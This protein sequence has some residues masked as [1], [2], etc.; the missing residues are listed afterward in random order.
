MNPHLIVCDL[1]GSLLNKEGNITSLSK[2]VLNTLID[3]GHTVVLA[4]G[5]P[6]GGAIDKYNELQLKTPLITDNGGSVDN[7][8]DPKFARQKTYIPLFVMHDLFRY[9]KSFII[10][11]FYT[12]NGV[13]YAYQYDD[14]LEDFFSGINSGI[15]IDKEMTEFTVPPTGLI[16]LIKGEFKDQLE[17]YINSNF[18]D[19]ISFRLWGA[20]NGEYMYEI[21][22]A[23]VSKASAIRY[24]I[25]CCHLENHTWMSFGDGVNDVDMIKD[26]D[27]GVAMKNA[28]PE[29]FE[30]CKDVT[31]F[32]HNED[33]L[34]KYLIK[35]FKLDI[36]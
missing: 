3:Q 25:E 12:E 14:R 32:D 36:E 9:S 17:N 1:D 21:Y 29:L 34:A 35:K 6:Y 22:L 15:V 26:A 31:D 5:R 8:S 33:G 7:P 19:I 16:Y 24:V 2:K 11:A 13:V 28:V 23:H 27:F 10:S 20:E 30:V 18:K 4:T